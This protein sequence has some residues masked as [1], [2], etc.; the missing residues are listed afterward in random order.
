MKSLITN[1]SDLPDFFHIFK[2]KDHQKHKPLLLQ[3]INEMIL[4]NNIQP[5]EAGYYYD[6]YKPKTFKPYGELTYKILEDPITQL[7]ELYG[8][9]RNFH[10]E[11]SLWFQQYEQTTEFGWHT[12]NLDMSCVYYVELPEPNEATE[13]LHFGT[14]PVEEGD[15]ITFPSFIAHRSPPI[16]SNKRK[17]IIACNFKF[18]IDRELVKLN[19]AEH[20]KH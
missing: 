17:T 18:N 8:V 4:N 5:N 15:V 19:G 11:L 1:R 3:K 10:V 6:F 7:E 2:I 13:F 14:F 9:Q 12:H 20:F 16:K